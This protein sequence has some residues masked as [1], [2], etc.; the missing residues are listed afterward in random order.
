MSISN[1][2]EKFVHELADMYD[3]EHQFLEAMGKMRDAATDS[4]LTQLLEQHIEQTERQIGRLDQVFAEMGEEPRRQECM[5]AK[6]L[7]QEGSKMMEEAG[8]PEVRDSVIAGAAAKAEHYEMV[9][10]ADLVDGAELMG[11]RKI[12]R[13]LTDNREEE[14]STAR[15]LERLSPRLGKAAA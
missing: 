5:G 7:V 4:K 9:G 13:L 14:M 6:G 1:S 2:Q 3:A 15:K 11:K 8:S 12:V 10:Y